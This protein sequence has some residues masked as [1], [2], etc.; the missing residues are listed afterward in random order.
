MSLPMPLPG[1]TLC[2]ICKTTVVGSTTHSSCGGFLPDDPREWALWASHHIEKLLQR[3]RTVD[4]LRARLRPEYRGHVF[5]TAMELLD[6]AGKLMPAGR[7]GTQLKIRPGQRI[8]HKPSVDDGSAIG[9][10][11]LPVEA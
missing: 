7:G 4:Q 2:A 8:S 10:F 9:L 11:E 6:A 5:T 3:P 1:A